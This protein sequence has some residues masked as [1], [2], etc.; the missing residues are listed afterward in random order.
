MPTWTS[1]RST[2]PPPSDDRRWRM[3]DTRMRRGGNRPDALIEVLHSVQELF[4]FLD[5]D[6]LA[7]V[8]TSLGVP[9][10]RVFGVATFYSSF[11]LKPPGDHSCVVCTG[12]ACYISGSAAIL[13]RIHDFTG[14]G[15]GETTADGRLS[16]LTAHCIGACSMAPAVII[17]GAISGKVTPD[18]V[19][20]LLESL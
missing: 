15:P 8:S 20:D 3:V 9:P 12:T 5:R 18:T 1:A 13:E 14:I 6:A 16:V 17:D 7:Y 11:K 2:P 4:G 19:N 10:S